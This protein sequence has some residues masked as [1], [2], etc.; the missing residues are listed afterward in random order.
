M[1]AATDRDRAQGSVLDFDELGRVPG[2]LAIVGDDNGED[3][4]EIARASTLGDEDGPI[5]V[6]MPTFNLPG[7]SPP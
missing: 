2:R 3:V 7:T 5:R 4:A 1:T 6:M